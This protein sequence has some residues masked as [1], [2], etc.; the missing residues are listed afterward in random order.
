MR[1]H[2]QIVNFNR[3]SIFNRLLGNNRSNLNDSNTRLWSLICCATQFAHCNS[4]PIDR[5][6]KMPQIKCSQTVVLQKEEFRSDWMREAI[7]KKWAEAVDNCPD[8]PLSPLAPASMN[9]GEILLDVNIVAL[10]AWRDR[11]PRM[12]K[13]CLKIKNI[14]RI[15]KAASHKLPVPSRPVLSCSAM[16]IATMMTKATMMSMATMRK[17]E[18]VHK[19]VGGCPISYNLQHACVR[20]LEVIWPDAHC[21]VDSSNW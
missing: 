7:T 11:I 1:R 19:E 17:L 3:K 4:E 14:A 21:R 5:P 20:K 13:N 18:V 16:T 10:P 8:A 15:A 6:L 9:T 12:V 2:L